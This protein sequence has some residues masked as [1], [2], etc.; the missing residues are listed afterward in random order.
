[1]RDTK[2]AVNTEYGKPRLYKH[3]TCT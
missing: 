3:L 2:N 1:M